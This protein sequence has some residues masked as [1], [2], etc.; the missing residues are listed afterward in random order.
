MAETTTILVERLVKGYV[1]P[2]FGKLFFAVICMI[3]GAA[4]TAA[5]AW[6]MQPILDDVF[7]K[8]DPQM[9]I[10]VPL[11]V[12]VIAI[13]KGVT[14]YGQA[15]LMSFVGQRIITDIQKKMYAHLM[16]ADLAFF[17]ANSAGGLVSRFINDVQVLR[18][19]V[20]DTLTGIGKDT[21]TLAFLI[22]VMFYQDWA[23]ALVAF[24]AFYS[25]LFAV[26]AIRSG[27]GI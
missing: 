24:F 3:L 10:L 8:R 13:I 2:Y 26:L 21:L 4:A 18:K 7:L 19:A 12:L 23:L 17:H 20:S 5:N 1:R 27:D 16:R 11:A 9:L 6:M 15:V 14:E 25:G 22:A